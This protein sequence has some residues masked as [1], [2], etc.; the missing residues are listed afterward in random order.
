MNF[1]LTVARVFDICSSIHRAKL[2]R[3]VR[4]LIPLS[5]VLLPRIAHGQ[6]FTVLHSFTLGGDGYAPHGTVV[7]D[8]SGSLYGT[9][10]S[11]GA[12]QWGTVYKLDSQGKFTVLYN[13][14]GGTD[15]G[16]P[17]ATLVRDS[18]GN[19]YGTADAGGASLASRVRHRRA[20]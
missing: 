3:G 4:A 19:L 6:T 5:I 15:G 17:F 2:L 9:T 10:A 20:G 13:F 1:P 7:R 12:N 11:G 18:A 14:T 8:A 16:E